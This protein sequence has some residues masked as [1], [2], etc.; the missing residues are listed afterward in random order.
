MQEYQHGLET[1]FGNTWRIVIASITAFWAG[2]LANGYV[3]A[4]LKIRTAG[5]HLW[6]RTIGSTAVGEAIDSSLFYM[7]AFYAIWPTEQVIAVAIAQYFLKTGWEV[8][9]TPVT[10]KIVAWLKNKEQEDY[11]DNDTNFTPFRVS[12]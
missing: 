2:S 12:L 1:V 8:I 4:K 10:Y 6:I 3:M 5:K 11:F 7:L 9:M